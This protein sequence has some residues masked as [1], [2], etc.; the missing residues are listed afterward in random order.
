M[1]ERQRAV[2]SRFRW[3]HV[4]GTDVLLHVA[5]RPVWKARK[6]SGRERYGFGSVDGAQRRLLHRR[7]TKVAG[8]DAAAGP[9]VSLGSVDDVAG[10][11]GSPRPCILPGDGLIDPD[12]AD[13][14]KQAGIAIG[15]G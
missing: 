10:W 11:G 4:G 6:E 5:R 15:L 3:C 8:R 12:V 2:V 7:E 9:L 1:A 13:I 14:P